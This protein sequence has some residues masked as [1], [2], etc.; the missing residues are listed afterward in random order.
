MRRLII[1]SLLVAAIMLA[2]GLALTGCGTASESAGSQNVP[3]QSD[4]TP[5]GILAASL[6]ASEAITSAAASYDL[7]LS[8]D[9]DRSKVPAEELSL[10][11]QPMKVS[12]QVA[13]ATQPQ[14]LDLTMDA[15]IAGQTMNVGLKSVGGKAYIALGGQWYEMPAEMT[16]AFTNSSSQ[17]GSADQ[18]KQMLSGLGI[19][20]STWLSDVKQVGEETVDGVATYHLQA[21]PNLTAI[22]ADVTK[23][24]QS[25]QFAGIMGQTASTTAPDGTGVTLP[26]AQGME[27]MLQQVVQMFKDLKADVWVAKDGLNIVK[28][29]IGA[30]MVP[31]AGEDSGGVNAINLSL[32][33]TMKDVGKPVSVEAPASAKS[34]E[35]FQKDLQSNPSLLGP[36]GGMGSGMFGGTQ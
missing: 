30:Q 8:F 21:T 10:L 1:A 24:M 3:Q 31:P 23:L 34:W 18:M 5:A 36:L 2:V 29:S 13:F 28:A 9:V 14:A 12:G 27:G 19:N 6:T 11:D 26:S 4:Q 16:Q 35:D 25:E 22:M 32:T 15:S 33:V 20:P 17:S 7:S